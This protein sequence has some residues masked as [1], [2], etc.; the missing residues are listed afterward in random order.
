VIVRN[1]SLKYWLWRTISG[2]HPQINPPELLH[3]VC[4]LCLHAFYCQDFWQP[5]SENSILEQFDEVQGVSAFLTGLAGVFH[6]WGKYSLQAECQV[7]V[8][9]F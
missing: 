7:E 8:D 6:V 5:G 4:L 1:E 2:I 9:C 3:S